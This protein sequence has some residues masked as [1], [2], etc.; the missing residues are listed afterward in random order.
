MAL[1]NL[2][3]NFSGAM[4]LVYLASGPAAQR[5]DD[6]AA[7]E[8]MV[9]TASPIDARKDDGTTRIP[10]ADD[11]LFYVWGEVNG[12]RVR[13]LV[14]TGASVTV[15]TRRDAQRVGVEIDHG[16]A[17]TRMRTAS[18]SA[19]MQWARMDR[20]RL[21]G[22]ELSDLDAAVMTDGPAVSLLG[23]NLLT[24]LGTVT[25]DGNQLHLR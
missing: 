22:R 3:F 25:I 9:A 1:G 12:I 24:K 10:R 16:Q 18:G 5:F 14:D 7:I 19:H 4:A 17:E 13:F 2:A 21:A 11:G 6:G 15:L 20:V 8:P 23:Q